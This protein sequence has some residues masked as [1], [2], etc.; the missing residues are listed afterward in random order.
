MKLLIALLFA[1]SCNAAVVAAHPV[2]VPHVSPVV[3]HVSPVIVPHIG[4][5]HPEPMAPAAHPMPEEGRG[6]P[7]Y[8]VRPVV[9]H[10]GSSSASQQSEEAVEPQDKLPTWGIVVMSIIGGV[11]IAVLCWGLWK[12][13]K[14]MRF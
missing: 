11:M 12:L 8:I 10:M 6:T 14:E 1:A 9:P 5:V 3:P 13:E 4:T 2:C 7:T